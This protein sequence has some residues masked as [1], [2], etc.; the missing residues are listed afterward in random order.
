MAG[1][2]CTTTGSW[3]RRVRRDRHRALDHHARV[4]AA[5]VPRGAAHAGLRGDRPRAAGR[6]LARAAAHARRAHVPGRP[7]PVP[8]VLDRPRVRRL[9]APKPTRA[10]PRSGRARTFAAHRS[11]VYSAAR[12]GPSAAARSRC[13]PSFHAA[14]RLDQLVHARRHEFGE[15]RADLGHRGAVA[16][17]AVARRTPSPRGS[18]PK[19]SSSDGNSTAVLAP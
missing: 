6:V 9:R 11:S 5:R 13:V 3:W 17:D 16:R 18:A 14:H 15:A 8:V 1:S 2:T 4:P 7:V 12:G 19:P 10:R